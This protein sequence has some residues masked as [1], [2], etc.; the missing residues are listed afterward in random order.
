[1]V[2]VLA[3]KHKMAPFS[4]KT[5]KSFKTE[6]GN[7]GGLAKANNLSRQICIVLSS[8]TLV[9]SELTLIKIAHIVAIKVVC[10]GPFCR[11]SP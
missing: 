2:V 1:M 3:I 4:G 7:F 10:L 5:S 9:K 8:G 6:R 11:R